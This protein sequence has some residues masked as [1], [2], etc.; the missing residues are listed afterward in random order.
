[1]FLIGQRYEKFSIEQKCSFVWVAGKLEM[2]GEK[3]TRVLTRV[4]N[5]ISSGSLSSL[6][7][8]SLLHIYLGLSF[9]AVTR[10]TLSKREEFMFGDT[11]QEL[12]SKVLAS[13]TDLLTQHNS[14]D[15]KNLPQDLVVDA[16]LLAA[17]REAAGLSTDANQVAL[18][19]ILD[20]LVN[21]VYLCHDEH[22][23]RRVWVQKLSELATQGKVHGA[24]LDQLV[25][26]SD[27]H[28][29]EVIKA[30][31]QHQEALKKKKRAAARA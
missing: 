22:Q 9:R 11:I 7:I 5:E 15:L 21:A 31:L 27:D 19:E 23:W 29:E 20:R 24:W 18:L 28:R 17:R 14:N 6:P 26:R 13:V 10:A 30:R 8:S 25:K 3:T 16:T 2:T 1:M 12:E 4:L